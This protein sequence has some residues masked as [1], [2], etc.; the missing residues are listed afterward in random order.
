MESVELENRKKNVASKLLKC[1]NLNLG[2]DLSF[3]SD[4]GKDFGNTI[5][6][7][8]WNRSFNKEAKLSFVRNFRIC[9]NANNSVLKV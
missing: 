9:L 8:G 3:A 7:I 5:Q 1:L 2:F 4:I 6:R